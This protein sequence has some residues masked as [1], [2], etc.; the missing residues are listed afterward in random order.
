MSDLPIG[1]AS[2][3][4]ENAAPYNVVIELRDFCCSACELRCFTR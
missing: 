4:V 1:K 3:H 2:V